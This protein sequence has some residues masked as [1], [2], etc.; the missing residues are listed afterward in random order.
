M[1]IL[2]V[3]IVL[4]AHRTDHPDNATVRPWLDTLLSS[5]VSF[6]VPRSVWASMLRIATHPRVFTVPTRI[7]DV[8]AFIDALVDQPGHVPSEP[9]GRHL[10]LLRRMCEEANARGGLVPDAV[11]AAIALEHG[12]AVASLDRDFARFPIEHVLPS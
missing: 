8:F 2:D 3:N 10:I 4:A 12:G 5:G 7:A 11:L 1:L 6:G 9:G